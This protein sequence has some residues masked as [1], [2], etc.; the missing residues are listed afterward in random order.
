M[1]FFSKNSKNKLFK[2]LSLKIQGEFQY[3]LARET[4][5]EM[6]LA[7]HKIKF[8]I[9]QCLHMDSDHAKVMLVQE[10]GRKLN[11]RWGDITE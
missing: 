1:S 5:S 3:I 6:V 11:Y 2:V 8:L 10:Y 4:K 7:S 9:N